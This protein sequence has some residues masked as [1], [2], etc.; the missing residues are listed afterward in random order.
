MNIHC[1]SFAS[2]SFKKTQDIQKK[3][4]LKVGFEQ[5][6]IHLYGPEKLDNKFFENF[7]NASEENKFGWFAFKPYFINL[8]LNQ[9][10][11]NDIL[12][13][14]D[15]ND[16]PLMGLKKYIFKSLLKNQQIDLIVPTTN[17][18]NF[19]FLSKFHKA[20]LSIEILVSSMFNLQPEAGALIIR[21]T[22][23][24][25]A[26]INAWYQLTILHAYEFEKYNE[27]KTRWDQETLFFL[28]RLYK[29][30]KFES[31]FLYKFTGDGL[32]KYIEF[33]SFRK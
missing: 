25:K 10:K 22:P 5:K 13:Y 17:Y 33:E 19:L 14:L 26:I 8:I 32:R 15:V 3:S 6:N 28:S 31:W 11:N 18:P 16:K 20:N 12:L 9:L 23:K 27:N 2:N 4:F 7:P 21:N 24:S 1:C 29:S 30:I